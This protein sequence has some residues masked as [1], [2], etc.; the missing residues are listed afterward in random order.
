MFLFSNRKFIKSTKFPLL[1]FRFTILPA[2]IRKKIIIL[3]IE[4]V[5]RSAVQFKSKFH[6]SLLIVLA[7]RTYSAIKVI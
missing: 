2:K 1:N 7:S 3:S 5:N 4:K 6:L